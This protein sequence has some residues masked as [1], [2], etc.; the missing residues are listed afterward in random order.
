MEE[1]NKQLEK[2]REKL[3]RERVPIHS[4]TPNELWYKNYDRIFKKR[5]RK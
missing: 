5:K 4:K 3:I 2:N 1:K